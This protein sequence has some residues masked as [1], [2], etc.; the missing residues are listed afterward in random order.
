MEGDSA[1]SA[2]RRG[3]FV[4]TRSGGKDR[5][6]IYNSALPLELYLDTFNVFRAG[7]LLPSDEL[8]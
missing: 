5:H 7:L 3:S 6:Y 2:A 4:E 1:D 8:R